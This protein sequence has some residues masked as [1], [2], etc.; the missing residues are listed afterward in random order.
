M[1]LLLPPEHAN[2]GKP[3]GKHILENLE[4][5]ICFLCVY[6]LYLSS[7]QTTHI[8]TIYPF[9]IH[10]GNEYNKRNAF[11]KAFFL[12]RVYHLR[13]VPHSM[14]RPGLSVNVHEWRKMLKY[15]CGCVVRMLTHPFSWASVK[16]EIS[17]AKCLRNREYARGTQAAACVFATQMHTNIMYTHN[18]IL[19]ARNPYNGLAFNCKKIH[20]EW[21]KSHSFPKSMENYSPYFVSGRL[22][23]R[24]KWV[25]VCC[26]EYGNSW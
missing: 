25:R 19:S 23:G 22:G 21:R 26:A 9:N 24:W 10:F 13:G 18:R 17:S 5:K 11:C 3:T 15:E 16:M 6:V 20:S 1:P 4:Y 14:L 7:P 12:L 2:G 8:N